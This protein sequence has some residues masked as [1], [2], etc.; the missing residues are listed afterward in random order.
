MR[1]EGSF[2]C[3]TPRGDDAPPEHLCFWVA[4]DAREMGGGSQGVA[5]TPRRDGTDDAVSLLG[6]GAG[7]FATADSSW[8]SASPTPRGSE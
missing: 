3:A 1:A 8:V 7:L 2:F 5:S 6:A 4:D